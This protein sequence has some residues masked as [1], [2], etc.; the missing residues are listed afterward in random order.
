MD[1][2]AVGGASVD[3]SEQQKRR[4][5]PHSRLADLKEKKADFS[6]VM[7][8]SEDG[9]LRANKDRSFI[10]WAIVT[11]YVIGVA[12]ILIFLAIHY[13]VSDCE[14]GDICA[15]AME[16][17][18][19]LSAVLL[20]IVSVVILPVVTLVLGFYFGSRKAKQGK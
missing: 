9:Q 10:S 8:A 7:S 16:S 19:A 4:A 18:K 1:Q 6:R 13:P 14:K 20:K 15:D 17:W 2:D 5:E 12:G 11:L 3:C